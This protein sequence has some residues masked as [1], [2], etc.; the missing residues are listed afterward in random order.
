MINLGKPTKH[1]DPPFDSLVCNAIDFMKQSASDLKRRPKYSVIN[2]CAGLEIFLKAR[3]ILEHWSLVDTKPQDAIFEKFRNG[4]FHSVTMNEALR[5]LKNVAG[6]K[7]NLQ[8]EE[9]F[10]QVRVHRNKFV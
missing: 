4:D 5:R 9:C 6:E 1:S 8:E 10:K 3:L 7:F 2:F